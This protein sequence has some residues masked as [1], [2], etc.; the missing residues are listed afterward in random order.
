MVS[1]A[2]W[3]SA[4]PDVNAVVELLLAEL[5]AMLARRLIGL[6]LGGSLAGGDFDPDSSDVDFLVVTD[7]EVPEDL[8]PPL[9]AMHQRIAAG[10]L[11]LATKLE[12]SYIPVNALGRYDPSNARHPSIGIDWDF[13]VWQHGSEW[14]IQRHLIREG[15]VVVCGP[16]VKTLIE[17]VTADELRGAVRDSLRS[18]WAEQLHGP[19]W[20]RS[21]E[22]QAFAI[23]TMCRALYTLERGEVVSKPVAAAWARATLSGEWT[24]L[25]ERALAW[26]HDTRPDD[27]SEMLRFVRYTV[28][29]AAECER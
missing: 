9:A 23:L 4:Y 22:Y 14:I 2:A 26:R 21:R 6:Y 24:P 28:D 1:D 20:L 25:I 13:G 12:G 18:F 3:P 15:G 5:R 17:P 11:A 10:G 7:E 8:L 19:D 29:F 27:M 16:P